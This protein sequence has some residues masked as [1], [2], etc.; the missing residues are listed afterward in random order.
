MESVFIR[1]PIDNATKDFEGNVFLIDYDRW[2]SDPLKG[3]KEQIVVPTFYSYIMTKREE[4]IR[5]I[6]SADHPSG[7]MEDLEN[8][9]V[10]LFNDF[11]KGRLEEV[12]QRSPVK[13]PK[14][15]I[16]ELLKVL[17]AVEGR[18]MIPSNILERHPNISVYRQQQMFDY[19]CKRIREGGPDP[20]IPM[21][22]LSE[23]DDVYKNYLRYLREF[24]LIS[25]D[26]LAAIRDMYILLH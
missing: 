19:L 17:Q 7:A 5:F 12:L 15:V 14:A 23:W 16:K 18:I 9:F 1:S 10:K 13:I 24:T 22:P 20:F 21:H 3:E 11:R 25:K 6:S 2:Q 4:L 8:T 26:G